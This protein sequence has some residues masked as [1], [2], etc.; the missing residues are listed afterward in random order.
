MRVLLIEDDAVVALSL[1]NTLRQH[2]HEVIGP[3]ATSAGALHAVQ[4]QKPDLVLI[5]TQLEG[6]LSGLDCARV[7]FKRYGIPVIFVTGDLDGAR[8]RR[9][10]ALGS[11]AKPFSAPTLIACMHAAERLLRGE[12]PRHVPQCF[13]LFVDLA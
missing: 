9:D 2:G 7:L 5:D 3:Y 6:Q 10:V 11:I 8:Q 12:R 1:E 13:E 4:S